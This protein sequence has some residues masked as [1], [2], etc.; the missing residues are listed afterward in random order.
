[1][2]NKTWGRMTM[3]LTIFLLVLIGGFVILID[4]FFH[5][6]KPLKSLEY[7][8]HSEWYQNDGIARNF[9]YNAVLTGTSMIEMTN[10]S[11]LDDLFGTK[12]VK[13]PYGGGS[14]YQID[15]LVKQAADS[16]SKLKIVIRGLDFNRLV[17]DSVDA[18]RGD[19]PFPEYLYNDNPFDDV[20]YIFNK[21][22][23]LN[24]AMYTILYTENG[25][26]T[27]S[28]DEY[29]RWEGDYQYGLTE[30]M[31]NNHLQAPKKEM[32]PIDEKE[33]KKIKENIRVNVIETAKANPDIDFYYFIPPYS[34]YAYDY[35]N[36]EGELEKFLEY[37]KRAM[38]MMLEVPNIKLYSFM[39]LYDVIENPD[40]Y[41]DEYHYGEWVNSTLLQ[42]L[43]DGEHRVTK[44]NFKSYCKKIDNYYLNYDYAALFEDQY[45]ASR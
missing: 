19:V 8:L 29:A 28:F 23:I 41:R 12:S 20:K 1:M 30:E 37:H 22:V 38:A 39:D 5:Y 32:L 24:E 7:K 26:K 15:S 14:Y 13:I 18:V 21:S 33:Y 43:N 36:R 45:L 31:I 6:H 3:A 17:T 42:C 27:T 25:Y 2:S 16:N 40:N 10:T 11:E 35:Y 44:D 9:K 34:V 4:P